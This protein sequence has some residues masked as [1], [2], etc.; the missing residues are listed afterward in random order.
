MNNEQQ[1]PYHPSS[2]NYRS[3]LRKINEEKKKRFSEK[4]ENISI[5]IDD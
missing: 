4:T 5:R 2:D 3:E 1:I